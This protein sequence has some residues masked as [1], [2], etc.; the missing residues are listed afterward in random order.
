MAFQDIV[1]ALLEVFFARA[2]LDDV[3]QL[4]ADDGVHL[5]PFRRVC[6]EIGLQ[7]CLSFREGR[8]LCGSLHAICT[9]F[10]LAY[11]FH[12]D[13]IENLLQHSGGEDVFEVI[14]HL[15]GPEVDNRRLRCFQGAFEDIGVFALADSRHFG[16]I[17]FL[18]ASF[19]R[20]RCQVLFHKRTDAVCVDISDER[21]DK[22]RSVGKPFFVHLHDAR[23]ADLLEIAG[24]D[25][26]GTRVVAVN[27]LC[28]RVAER[29][30]RVQFQVLQLCDHTVLEGSI[31]LFIHTRSREI[32]INQ[33]E[34]CLQ[35]GRSGITVY[36]FRIQADGGRAGDFLSCQYLVQ[37]G[38]REVAD[39]AKRNDIV[40]YFQVVDIFRSEQSA[41]AGAG[42]RHQDFVF[43]EIRMFQYDLDAVA[44]CQDRRTEQRVCL[45]LPDLSRSGQLGDQRF[46]G[47]CFLI[48]FDR[49]L[50]CLDKVFQ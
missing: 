43:L 20:E 40:E 45:H 48:G 1:P 36:V 24:R 4:C 18:D 28:Q 12:V 32:E 11:L 13:Q 30:H 29:H 23:V 34:Q 38:C 49:Q 8:N 42:G 25:A 50:L 44:E 16:G 21:K 27:R 19:C 39:S 47:N 5:F 6:V 22:V 3:I 15:T 9:A 7:E 26:G 33:F 10:V 35:V 2:G 14:F 41:A 17:V 31:S 37:I 46:V